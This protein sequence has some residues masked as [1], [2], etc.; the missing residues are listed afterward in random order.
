MSR[1][2]DGARQWEVR[3]MSDSAESDQGLLA[4]GLSFEAW[5]PMRLEEVEGEPPES[6]VEA[7]NDT[8]QRLLQA[9]T[10]ME[11][12]AKAVSPR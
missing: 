10:A 4:D 8:N 1:A 3:V 12:E 9:L 2:P 5:M 11:S 6:D 7:A